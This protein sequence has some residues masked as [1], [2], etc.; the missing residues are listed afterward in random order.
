MHGG[1]VALV[2]VVVVA[3]VTLHTMV[4]AWAAVVS[5]AFVSGPYWLSTG[6]ESAC[7]NAAIPAR[8]T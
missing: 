4:P 2:V 6:S 5:F 3:G 1:A 8:V 7:W